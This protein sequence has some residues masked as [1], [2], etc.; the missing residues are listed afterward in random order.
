MK[1][2]PI[3]FWYNTIVIGSFLVLLAL[4]LI[5]AVAWSWWWIFSPFWIP[6]QLRRAD[7]ACQAEK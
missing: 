6:K 4:K 3:Q 2:D 7:K 1:K 5:G